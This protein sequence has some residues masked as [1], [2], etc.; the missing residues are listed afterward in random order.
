[1]EHGK[2]EDGTKKNR[3]QTKMRQAV[4]AEVEKRIDKRTVLR[5]TSKVKLTEVL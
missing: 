2:N 5:Q 1:M 4:V 3:G